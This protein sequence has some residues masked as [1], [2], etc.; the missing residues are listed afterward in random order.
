MTAAVPVEVQIV[1]P[2]IVEQNLPMTAVLQPINSVELIAEVSG[3]VTNVYRKLGSRITKK[4]TLAIIDDRIPAIQYREAKAQVYS[5]EN[6]LKIAKLNLK[7]DKQL[8]ESGDISQI[9][10]ENSQLAAKNAEANY[11]SALANLERQEKNFKDTRIVSP[12]N[13]IISREYLELGQ[14]ANMGTP[15][16]RVIELNT[17]KLEVGLPQSAISEIHI[18][19]KA[20]I[21]VSALGKTVFDGEV[22]H[23]S[24]QADENTGTFPV[25]IHIKNNS[26]NQLKAG[27]TASVILYLSSPREEITIPEY[28]LVIKN[29]DNYVYKVINKIA[30]LTQFEAG[31]TYGDQ[32]AA[33]SGIADG[34]T[35]VVVGMKNLGV[36]TKVIYETIHE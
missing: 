26:A 31:K 30:H 4:D 9:A 22:R 5:A 25:E 21:R 20:E 19:S 15:L 17:L 13:G 33:E 12:I 16:Y 3:K 23:I 27:M 29:G 8:F 11:L 10:Y 36:D 24:P 35:V 28:A 18:G 6:N 2:Q 14:M 1:R 34:D 32:I 7:S